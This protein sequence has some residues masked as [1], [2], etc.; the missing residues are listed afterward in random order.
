MVIACFGSERKTDPEKTSQTAMIFPGVPAATAPAS[1][2]IK[3]SLGRKKSQKYRAVRHRAAETESS[4][5]SLLSDPDRKYGSSGL[6][7]RR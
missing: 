7:R 5:E 4:D 1:S 6:G 3:A 2:I